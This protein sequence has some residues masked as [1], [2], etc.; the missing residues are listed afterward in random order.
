MNKNVPGAKLFV[1]NK[2]GRHRNI[3]VFVAMEHNFPREQWSKIDLWGTGIL[4][5][6]AMEQCYV[7]YTRKKYFSMLLCFFRKA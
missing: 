7:A 2:V 4:D 6:H 5:A 1:C 3:T